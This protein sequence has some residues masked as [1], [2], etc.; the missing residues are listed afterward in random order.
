MRHAANTE[1]TPASA[2]FSRIACL[3][4]LPWPQL[5]H[6]DILCPIRQLRRSHV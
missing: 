1:E 2:C 6:W 4:I 3:Q 5:A